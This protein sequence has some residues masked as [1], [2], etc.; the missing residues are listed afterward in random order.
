MHSEQMHNNSPDT[1]RPCPHVHLTM[2][3]ICTGNFFSSQVSTMSPL[4]HPQ[5][6]REISLNSL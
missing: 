1:E 2:A 4:L 3:E 6:M 5:I